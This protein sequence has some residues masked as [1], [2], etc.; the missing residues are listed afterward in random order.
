MRNANE[1]GVFDLQYFQTICI[2]FCD[3]KFNLFQFQSNHVRNYIT[4]LNSDWI[5][6]EYHFRWFAVL[7]GSPTEFNLDVNL[8]SRKRENRNTISI[9]TSLSASFPVIE[10]G[11]NSGC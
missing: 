11:Q 5:M 3:Q 8:A 10:R 6:V 2:M 1:H 9:F 4:L 7:S